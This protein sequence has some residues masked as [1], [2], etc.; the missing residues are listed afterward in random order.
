MMKRK[1]RWT[2]PVMTVTLLLAGS[3]VTCAGQISLTTAVDLALK[4]DPRVKMA[5]ATVSK[6]TAV[7]AEAR[8]VYIPSVGVSGGYGASTGV[9]LSVP[10]VFSLSSD[11]LLFNFSQKDNVRAANEGV[12]SAQLALLDAQQQTIED[13][14]E[15]YLNLNN[16]E[17]REEAMKQEGM[18]AD[19]LVTIVQERLDAGQDTRMDLLKARRTTAQIK[20]AVLHNE[21]EIAALR[22]HLGRLIGMPGAQLVTEKD[23]IPA[24]P[25]PAA[26]DAAPEESPGVQS[27]Y[28]AALSKQ[29]EAFGASRYSYRPQVAF[30]ARYSRI[31]TTQTDYTLYYP[32][33]SQQHSDNALSVGLEITIPI[34]DYEHRAHARETEADAVH[35][36]AEA[37]SNRIQFLEGRSKLRRSLEELGA[38]QEIADLDREIAQEQLNTILIQLNSSSSDNG[39]ALTPKDEQSARLQER[40]KYVDMLTAEEDLD[41]TEIGLMRQSGML[42]DWVAK[43]M[44]VAPVNSSKP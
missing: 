35:A 43:A 27:S 13:A 28:A 1:A 41:Q 9:P 4:N 25:A 3:A 19:K 33:F 32:G 16:A 8:D 11:S 23:S 12:K 15:T 37:E 34:M 18:Y 20:L 36:L 39:A 30:G 24:L 17:R 40:Q 26:F 29:E 2:M 42:A 5:Q 21:D 7:L 44:Q 38:K 14:A 6:A 22:E 31:T 10:V